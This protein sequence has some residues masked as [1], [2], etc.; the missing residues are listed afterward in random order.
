MTITDPDSGEVLQ[1]RVVQDAKRIDAL[2]A[3][4]DAYKAA[5]MLACI[6]GWSDGPGAFEHYVQTAQQAVA[7]SR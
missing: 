6:D 1:E 4:A 2:L 5:L 3:E 7:A